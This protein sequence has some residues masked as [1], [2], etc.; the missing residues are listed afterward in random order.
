M[1]RKPG[2]RLAKRKAKREVAKASRDTKYA[3]QKGKG[4]GGAHAKS[5]RHR[6][7]RSPVDEPPVPVEHD[8]DDNGE[9]AEQTDDDRA[10][11]AFLKKHRQIEALKR[12]K[13]QGEV[14][15]KEQLAKINSEVKVLKHIVRLTKP[16]K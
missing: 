12:R 3:N 11:R 4:S 16:Q 15:N 14:L 2:S 7:K 5:Q 9:L 8:A 13:A 1:G 10:L 6:R